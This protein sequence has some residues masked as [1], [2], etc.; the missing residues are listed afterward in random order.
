[1]LTL[2]PAWGCGS[3]ERTL[4]DPAQLSLPLLPTGCAG[5]FRE[6]AADWPGGGVAAYMQRVVEEILP[7]LQQVGGPNT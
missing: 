1:M 6:D 7:W 5:G 3:C 2:L 4:S